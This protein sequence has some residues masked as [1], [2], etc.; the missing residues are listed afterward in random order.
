MRKEKTKRQ[1]KNIRK[2]KETEKQQKR[3]SFNKK[4]EEEK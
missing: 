1:I 2:C 4:W 3:K